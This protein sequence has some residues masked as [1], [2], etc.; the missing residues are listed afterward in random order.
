MLMTTHEV[1]NN[2]Y[3]L[4][5]AH[6]VHTTHYTAHTVHSTQYT[7]HSTQCTVHSAQHTAHSTQT[8]KP[9]E[10]TCEHIILFAHYL[11]YKKSRCF[12]SYFV[13]RRIQLFPL[14]CTHTKTSEKT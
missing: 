1:K 11:T 4:Y 2:L 3:I 8:G 14:M 7:V 5:T 6:T 13:Q 10:N 9:M 12:V